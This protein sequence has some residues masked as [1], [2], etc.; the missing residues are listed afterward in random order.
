[1]VLLCVRCLGRL[2]VSLDRRTIQADRSSHR[3]VKSCARTASSSCPP[4]LSTRRWREHTAAHQ[5]AVGSQLHGS[6]KGAGLLLLAPYTLAARTEKASTCKAVPKNAFCRA[7]LAPSTLVWCSRSRSSP[8]QRLVNDAEKEAE[9][10]CKSYGERNGRRTQHCGTFCEWSSK[11]CPLFAGAPQPRATPPMLVVPWCELHATC[12]TC[13]EAYAACRTRTSICCMMRT[14]TS[15][16]SEDSQK[17]SNF[18]LMA[19]TCS[20][21][22]TFSIREPTPCSF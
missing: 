15:T 2:T 5:G 10:R 14:E 11:S 20:F 22:V 21:P 12:D 17:H 8:W 18:F 16:L 6:R 7:M 13:S 19:T 4:A 9:G 1:M 3:D